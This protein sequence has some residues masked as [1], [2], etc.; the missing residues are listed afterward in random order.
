[1]DPDRQPTFTLH[2]PRSPTHRTDWGAQYVAVPAALLDYAADVLQCYV[3]QWRADRGGCIPDE[4]KSASLAVAASH[5]LAGLLGAQKASE[6]QGGLSQLVEQIED[7]LLWRDAREWLESRRAWREAEYIINGLLALLDESDR[8]A[9]EPAQ[10]ASASPAGQA[11]Q[12]SAA[13]TDA[14]WDF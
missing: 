9:K 11:E 6:D 5:A 2:V 1:M 3:A 4:A 10:Q 8:L 14:G 12:E 7:W 13:Q